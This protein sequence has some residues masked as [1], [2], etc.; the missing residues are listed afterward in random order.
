VNRVKELKIVS[1]LAAVIGFV[2]ATMSAGDD[3]LLFGII[4]IAGLVGFVAAEFMQKPH[5]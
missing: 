1:G 4:G 5:G 3:R 2:M